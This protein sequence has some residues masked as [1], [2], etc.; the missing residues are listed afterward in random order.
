M[1]QFTRYPLALT[2]NSARRW[3]FVGSVPIGL[4]YDGPIKAIENVIRFGGTHPSVSRRSWASQD[5]AIREA[6]RLGY[7]VA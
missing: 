7:T 6:D 1:T 5:D 4:K 3:F 2:H